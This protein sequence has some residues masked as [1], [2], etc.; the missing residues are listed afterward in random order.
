MGNTTV[1]T[2]QTKCLIYMF[3]SISDKYAQKHVATKCLLDSWV[4]Y[5]TLESNEK[6]TATIRKANMSNYV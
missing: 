5:Y 1:H 6:E 2:K 4:L 3:E